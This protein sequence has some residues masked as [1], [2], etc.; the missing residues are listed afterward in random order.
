[1]KQGILKGEYPLVP[2]EGQDVHLKPD[3]ND[4]N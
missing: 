1:M 2:K 4:N 3:V